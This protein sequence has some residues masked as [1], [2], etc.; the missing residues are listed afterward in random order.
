MGSALGHTRLLQ[1]S[2]QQ[3]PTELTCAPKA[4]RGLRCRSPHGTVPAWSRR[5][6]FGPWVGIFDKEGTGMNCSGRRLGRVAW[7]ALAATAM[8]LA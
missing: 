5:G 6:F 8:W 4:L 7:S 3:T 1:V 2:Y